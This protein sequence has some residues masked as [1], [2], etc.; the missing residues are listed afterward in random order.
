MLFF[1]K[2]GKS[3]ER[4][5]LFAVFVIPLFYYVF[6]TL[7]NWTFGADARYLNLFAN[8]HQAWVSNAFAVAVWLA[9]LTSFRF[10]NDRIISFAS[11][12]FNIPGCGKRAFFMGSL[13][14]LNLF[15]IRTLMPDSDNWLFLLCGI[16]FVIYFKMYPKKVW[17]L[18]VDH[19]FIGV[20]SVIVYTAY[21]GFILVDYAS[22]STDMMPNPVVFLCFIPTY[23][24]LFRRKDYKILLVLL[25]SLL[26]FMSGKYATNALPILMYALYLNFMDTKH[27]LEHDRLVRLLIVFSLMAYLFVPFLEVAYPAMHTPLPE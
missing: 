13:F 3:N 19:M 2:G 16:I 26:F 5:A 24:I 20:L 6:F 21:R 27:D 4:L 25:V 1:G 8:Y 14:L 11:N 7:N 22:I 9:I 17:K 10:V 23:Y 18:R 12:G 15:N